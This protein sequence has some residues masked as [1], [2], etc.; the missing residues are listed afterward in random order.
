M[1]NLRAFRY[2]KGLQRKYV[3][4]KIGISGR[5]LNDIEVGK[6]NLTDNVAIKMAEVYG[7]SLEIIKYLYQGEK[8]EKS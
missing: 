5:H 6:V 1:K 4:E 8:N 7:V 3:A 2:D